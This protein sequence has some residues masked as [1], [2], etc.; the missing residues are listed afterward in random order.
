M[1]LNPEISLGIRP[2]QPVALPPITSPLDRYQKMLTLRHLMTQGQLDTQN[3][4]TGALDLETKQLGL[5]QKRQA[6]TDDEVMRKAYLEVGDDLDKLPSAVAG[7]VSGQTMLNLRKA[8]TEEKGRRAKLSTDQL[9]LAQKQTDLIRGEGQALISL[10][11]EER[12]AAYPVAR[13]RLIAAGIPEAGL[14]PEYDERF[15]LDGL[16]RSMQGTAWLKKEQDRRAELLKIVPNTPE[17]WKAWYPELPDEYRAVISPT[18]SKEEEARVREM[19]RAAGRQSTPLRPPR[20]GLVDAI[21]AKPELFH[22][23]TDADKATVIPELHARGFK[24]FEKQAPSGLVEAVTANPSLWDDLSKTDKAKVIPGL[25]AAGF[26]EFGSPLNE[27]AITKI[28]DTRSGIGSLRDLRDTLRKNQ[29]LTGPIVGL[30]AQVPYAERARTLQAQID[31]VKQRVGRAF[32]GGVLRKEDEAKYARILPTIQ[33]TPGVA[34]AKA[35]IVERELARD[36][37]IYIETQKGAGRRTGGVEKENA[38]PTPPPPPQSLVESVV[39]QAAAPAAAQTPPVIARDPR[40][41]TKNPYPGAPPVG[42][43]EYDVNGVPHKYIGGN[44]RDTNNW[45]VVHQVK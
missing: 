38:K 5:E 7:K 29:D 40:D 12:A 31:L 45:P 24:Q 9:T 44:H 16:N 43:I 18:H 27:S 23:L 36:L 32:E 21:I 22:Q 17:G 42:Q 8:I 15:V 3:L 39:N 11:P 34:A 14:P 37:Q 35:D 33:D 28:T 19:G 20:P 6:V 26:Q 2:P 10:K 4:Q 30:L 25:V 1:A 41:S 13:Q